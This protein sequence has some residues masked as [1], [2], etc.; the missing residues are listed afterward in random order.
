MSRKSG[1][2]FPDKDKR[3]IKLILEN[4]VQQGAVNF[5]AAPIVVDEAQP[6]KLVH[7]EADA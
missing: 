3:K 1:I 2:R 4:H 6:A 5:E 7:E